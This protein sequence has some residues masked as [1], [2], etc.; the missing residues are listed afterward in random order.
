M[1][2]GVAGVMVGVDEPRLAGFGISHFLEV[3][4]REVQQLGFRHFTAFAT[5]GHMELGLPDA[6]VGRTVFSEVAGK[7]F[8][9]GFTCQTDRPEVPHLDEPGKPFRYL[10]FVVTHSMEVRA[11][12]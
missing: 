4:V 5:D 6:A 11:S 9:G 1:Q 3:P 2:V 12:G 7:L 10:M 8:R